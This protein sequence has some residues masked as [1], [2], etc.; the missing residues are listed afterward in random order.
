MFAVVTLMTVGAVGKDKAVGSIKA[1]APVF[2][3]QKGFGRLQT[4]MSEDGGSFVSVFEWASKADHEAC[5]MS[6]DFAS[7]NA[8]WD[9]RLL[10]PPVPG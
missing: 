10:Q 9:E 1:S 3:R 7:L 6:A 8:N 5:M 4:F 2:A